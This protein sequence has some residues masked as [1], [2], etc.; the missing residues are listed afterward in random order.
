MTLKL[1]VPGMMCDG[2]VNSIT[3]EIKT[4][5]P[6]ATVEANLESKL[7]TVETTKMAE[8]ELKSIIAA[9]GYEV[10]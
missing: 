8:Q 1:T 4:H 2:C 6:N 5:D 10:A 9:A 3:S 7:L